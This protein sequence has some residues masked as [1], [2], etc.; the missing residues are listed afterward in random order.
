M[1][2]RRKEIIKIA[3]GTVF[4]IALFSFV[5]IGMNHLGFAIIANDAVELPALSDEIIVP[6]ILEQEDF[7]MPEVTLVRARNFNTDHINED[8]IFMSMEEAARIGALYIW[9]VFGERIDGMMVEMDYM[10][11]RWIG[12]VM[13][14]HEEF[15]HF[16]QKTSQEINDMLDT[17][18]SAFSELMEVSGDIRKFYFAIDGITGAR[19]AI[20]RPHIFQ[21]ELAEDP[22]HIVT[23][24]EARAAVDMRFHAMNA[25]EPDP[26]PIILSESEMELFTQLART[27]AQR[28]LIFTNVAEVVFDYSWPAEF[29]RDENGEI[30]AIDFMLNFIITDEIGQIISMSIFWNEQR[31]HGL[32]V[33]ENPH[34][35]NVPRE[36]VPIE[37]DID[38]VWVFVRADLADGT[39]WHPEYNDEIWYEIAEGFARLYWNNDWVNQ[40]T[41]AV[42]SRTDVNQFLLSDNV[43]I[44][45]GEQDPTTIP[46]D[47]NLR[48][49]PTT[50][51][52]RHYGHAY[53]NEG[54]DRLYFYFTR[55]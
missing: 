33:W 48:Y 51:L 55:G 53:T 34:R 49:D 44:L 47:S 17:D 52:L 46:A 13:V 2:N 14:Y 39:P 6:E 15:L 4:A 41:E 12:I 40:I 38:G 43:R 32:N 5:F 37:T 18:L 8:D 27:Y 19:L 35:E 26:F 11:L 10:G 21:V 20:N 31:L 16:L 54:L 24:E 42:L 7:V 29:G 3:V 50:R 25:G 1:Y 30:I 45:N 9:D 36:H 23:R 22:S 28:H